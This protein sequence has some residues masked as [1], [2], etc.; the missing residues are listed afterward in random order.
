MAFAEYGKRQDPSVSFYLGHIRELRF[1]QTAYKR[2]IIELEES[3]SI[4]VIFVKTWTM[5]LGKDIRY[6]L[7]SFTT[8][9]AIS[10]DMTDGNH[11]YYFHTLTRATFV[12]EIEKISSEMNYLSEVDIYPKEQQAYPNRTG[13]P[14]GNSR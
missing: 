3:W 8:Y 9:V 12:I 10:P 7:P 1:I 5:S 6:W 14:E 13:T 11:D 4:D 2:Y